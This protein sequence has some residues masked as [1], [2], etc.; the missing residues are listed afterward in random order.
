MDQVYVIRDKV[1]REHKSVRKAA[2]EAGISRVTARKYLEGAA[3][4]PRRKKP[5]RDRP[6]MQVVQAR[7]EALLSEWAPRTTTKQRVTATRLHQALLEEQFD[8]GITTVRVWLAEEKRKKAEVFVPLP[9]FEGDEGQVDFFE[10]TVDIDGVRGKAWMLVIRLMQSGRDFGWLYRHCD[11]VSFLDG[12]VRAFA[13]FGGVP[14]R[15]LYDNLKAAVAKILQVGRE[16]SGRFGAMAAHYVFEPC[17][18]R[19]YT[20]HDK[21]GVESRGR[22]VRLQHL[23]PIP[24]A[25]TLALAAQALLERLDVQAHQRR[26]EDGRTVMQRFEQD[27]QPHMLLVLR[28]G[29][30]PRKLENGWANGSSITRLAGAHYSVP[31]GWARCDV[32]ARV[33]VEEVEIRCRGEA[34]V[35]PRQAKGGKYI[36]YRYYLPELRRKPQAVRQV[37]PILLEQLGEPFVR[38]WRLLVDM[39]G[40]LDAARKFARVLGALHEHGDGP[41]RASVTAALDQDRMELLLRLPRRRDAQTAPMHV[42][43]ALA[44]HQVEARCD[45]PV[46]AWCAMTESNTVARASDSATRQRLAPSARTSGWCEGL[47]L[48]ASPVLVRSSLDAPP[49]VDGDAK[50]IA[51]SWA[52][53]V[54]IGGGWIPTD[55]RSTQQQ[56]SVG[57]RASTKSTRSP[58]RKDPWFDRVVP[59]PMEIMWM[60]VERRHLRVGDLAALLLRSVV[61]GAADFEARVGGRGADQA[62]DRLVVDQRLAVPVHADERKEGVF[63][64]GFYP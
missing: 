23:V 55:G 52:C 6:V 49:S 30:D 42:P 31:T 14:Q 5:V 50:P 64:T 39:D 9:H 57:V 8:V 20:G 15:L 11:Q 32:E 2:R 40:P 37:M 46:L 13:H 17:F 35:V 18:A 45:W 44:H 12:H 25:A 24:A 53:P 62:D 19:P 48:A 38:L 1:L 21:G 63:N 22:G 3:E 34:I 29:F 28:G 58:S 10:V 33:G 36:D 56:E 16:L 60:Q 59:L 43:A 4:P 61:E 54:A 7:M 47:G 41:V 26:G 27:E 51:D